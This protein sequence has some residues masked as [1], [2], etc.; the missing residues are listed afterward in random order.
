MRNKINKKLVLLL[1]LSF[2][3]FFGQDI[4]W[5]WANSNNSVGPSHSFVTHTALDSDNNFYVVGYFWYELGFENLHLTSNN[6]AKFIAK[7][8]SAGNIIWLK[9][10]VSTS[11]FDIIGLEIDN[12]NN[13][14]INGNIN[15]TYFT[16]NINFN[17]ENNISFEATPNF[18]NYRHFSVKVNSNG[19]ILWS[20][21]DFG[22][23][24]VYCSDIDSNNNYYSFGEYNASLVVEGTTLNSLSGNKDFYLLKKND[25]NLIWAKKFDFYVNYLSKSQLKITDNNEIVIIGETSVEDFYFQGFNYNMGNPNIRKLIII[26]FDNDGN[27]ISMNHIL[28][29]L[30]NDSYS[31]KY[32]INNQGFIYDYGT[33]T[34]N[35]LQVNSK[36][37]NKIGKEDLYVGKFDSSG[38]LI[39]ANNIGLLNTGFT[40]DKLIEKNNEL[41]IL[42]DFYPNSTININNTNHTCN[43]EFNT[44]ILK[45]DNNFNFIW[46]KSTTGIGTTHGN[47]PNNLSIS[48]NNEMFI[49]G[50]YTCENI[51]FDN[52]NLLQTNNIGGYLKIFIAKLT[53][54]SNLNGD[55]NG[56]VYI[57]PNP[58]SQTIKFN[59]TIISDFIIYDSNGKA[60]KKGNLNLNEQTIDINNLEKGIYALVI[61]NSTYRFIKN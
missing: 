13:V 43:G 42:T 41:Y 14:I 26:K 34:D 40:F 48:N 20:D 55:I 44:L 57:Y 61:N 35:T 54:S 58:T 32:L 51:Q 24:T 47:F 59:S 3:I 60:T 25:N 49:T 38:N 15:L 7:Y 6:Y 37:L 18:G 16:G 30:L 53:D 1:L 29:P 28:N 36:I 33:F 22:K 21:T 31:H 4:N 19:I 56:N 50:A 12:N 10:L 9:K 39:S 8:N 5:Q 46:T 17:D 45:L 23:S 11:D 27:L 52:F 2:Q